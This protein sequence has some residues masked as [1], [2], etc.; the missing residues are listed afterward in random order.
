M[1]IRTSVSGG[2]LT[3]AR[4]GFQAG[5]HGIAF[6]LVLLS[7][8]AHSPA[9]GAVGQ[10]SSCGGSEHYL[11]LGPPPSPTQPFMLVIEAGAPALS[12]NLIEA[13][14]SG[15]V[16]TVTLSGTTTQA[17]QACGSVIVTVPSAGRYEIKLY[18]VRDGLAP[19][20]A[21][22]RIVLLPL[23]SNFTFDSTQAVGEIAF[24]HSVSLDGAAQV[25]IPIWVPPGRQGIQPS[26]QLIYSSRGGDGALGIGW[27][28]GGLS[29]ITACRRTPAVDEAFGGQYP[30]R[31]CLDGMR[32]VEN[33]TE[34]DSYRNII[35]HGS[36]A[37]PDSFD[38]FSA[39]GMIAR[40]GSRP[41]AHSVIAGLVSRCSWG[42]VNNSY[43]GWDDSHAG[44]SSGGSGDMQRR[45][46]ML[47]KVEDRFGNSME[48]DY[49]TAE[50]LLP[51]EIR[52]TYH[53]AAPATKKI[54]LEYEARP[55]IRYTSIAGLTYSQSKRLK[56]IKIMGPLGL[57]HSTPTN[58]GLLRRYEISYFVHPVTLQSTVQQVKECVD[59]GAT[60]ICKQ[61]LTF[62]YSGSDGRMTYHD[63]SFAIDPANAPWLLGLFDGFRTADI[64]GD[65][66]DDLLY[67]NI[68]KG[69]TYH[70]SNGATFGSETATGILGKFADAELGISLV[71][72]NRDQTVDG[73]IP[74]ASSGDYRIARG[75]VNGSFS[76]SVLPNSLFV[77]ADPSLLR[78]TA[79]GDLDGDTLPDLA[80]RHKCRTNSDI[81][82]NIWCRWATAKNI[83]SELTIEFTNA[84][85]FHSSGAPCVYI[86][87]NA[88][89][90]NCAETR[91]GDPAFMIDLDGNGQ[92]EL[93][94]PVRKEANGPFRERDYSLELRALSFPIGTGMT[95][96]GTGLSS[97][98]MPRVF[99]DVNGDGL[100]DAA[101]V[102]N[103]SLWVAMNVGGSF[104]SPQRAPISATAAAAISLPNEMRVG[105]FNNDGLEDVYLV[106]ADIL[107]QANG[108][109]GFV[110]RSL[111]LPAGT[112]SCQTPI[113]PGVTRRRWDQTLDFNGDGL[114]DF[115]QM[116]AGQIHV[117][118][119]G[120][121]AP[122][123]LQT[124]TGGP[125][126]PEVRFTYDS[127]P[128]VHTPGTCTYPQYCLRKGMRLVAE[129]GVKA[130]VA[131]QS[132]PAGFNRTT[133]RY[134]GGRF[135]Q[136]GRGWLGFAEH[137]KTDMQTGATVTT[138][139]DNTTRQE[140]L[141]NPSI[142][143][144]PG[145]LR[146]VQEI[147]RIDS[148]IAGGDTGKIHRWTLNY[149]YDDRF[150][151]SLGVRVGVASS[152]LVETRFV[153]E[154]ATVQGSAIGP[155]VPI[156]S[157]RELFIRNDF[158]LLMNQIGE[159][160]EGG[161]TTN[162]LIPLNAKVTRLEITRTPSPVN[163]QD[164]L[165]RR[166]DRLI[167]TSTEPARDAVM[168]SARE[169][170]RPGTPKQV[171]VRT[172]DV[173]WKSGTTAIDRITIEP[174]RKA[175]ASLYSV[176]E[177]LHDP[178]GNIHDIQI[179]A[180]SG[181]GQTTH[182]AQIDWDPLDQTLEYRR[183]NA[184]Q[185][186][187]TFYYHAGIG[188][189]VAH[190]DTNGLRTTRILDL[191]GRSRGAFSPSLAGSEISYSTS[192]GGLLVVTSTA[193][194][195]ELD[196]RYINRYGLTVREETS[197]LHG[198]MSIVTR[199]FTRLNELETQT[200]PHYEDEQTES[201]EFSYDNL[202]RITERS[203]GHA[204]PAPA[205]GAS[206]QARDVSR[207]S[208]FWTYDGLTTQH[209]NARGV[210]SITSFDAAGRLVR[211]ATIEPETIREIV[212]R[213]EYGPFDVVDAV[214][215]SAGN[216]IQNTYDVLGRRIHMMDPAFGDTV[217]EYNGY[218]EA[219]DVH[220][221]AGIST[222]LE[223]D[224]LG[225]IFRE[226]HTTPTGVLVDSFVWDTAANGL[227]MLAEATSS[228]NI[229]TT[230]VYDILGRLSKKQWDVPTGSHAVTSYALETV[231]D[232]YD[233]PQFLKYPPVGSR[234]LSLQYHYEPQG[235]LYKITNPTT[236]ELYWT[237][238]KQDASG[239]ALT[240]QFMNSITTNRYLDSR[241]R[242]KLLETVRTMPS[243]GT[244]NNV[245][246]LQ[247]LAYEYGSGGLIRSRH[248]VSED[249]AARIT[250]DFSYDFLGRLMYW[251]AFQNCRVSQ[252]KYV[253]D[254][255]GNVVSVELKAGLGRNAILR[256]GSSPN[257]PHAGPCAVR[258]LEED[259]A[260]TV[261]QYDTGGRQ[262]GDGGR[263]ITWSEFDLPRRIQTAT[264]DITFKYDAARQRTV[265]QGGS[266]SETVSI[267]AEY[268]KYAASSGDRHVFNLVG[269]AGVFGQVTWTSTGADETAFFYSD[270][271]G[272]PETLSVDAAANASQKVKYEPFGQRRYPL[273]IA[274]PASVPSDRSIG[275]TGHKAE[276][277]FGLVDMRGRIYDPRIM[278][279]LT[280]DPLVQSPLFSQALNRY[281]YVYNNPV[282]FTDPTGFQCAD[283]PTCISQSPGGGGGGGGGVGGPVTL[284]SCASL[285]PLACF[286]GNPNSSNTQPP[287]R[288]D[289]SR[290]GSDAGPGWGDAA[291]GVASSTLNV[292]GG[293]D[294]MGDALSSADLD[295]LPNMPSSAIGL[296]ALVG[297]L[298]ERDYLGATLNF[299]DLTGL[300]LEAGANWKA[301]QYGRAGKIFKGGAWRWAK[302]TSKGGEYAP[303]P[304]KARAGPWLRLAGLG[305]A[306]SALA[307][308]A[309]LATAIGDTINSA[310]K[311][312][313]EQN[314]V[315]LRNRFSIFSGR[316]DLMETDPAYK[317]TIFY[318]TDMFSGTP[319]DPS[320][321]WKYPTH[322][323]PHQG[324]GREIDPSCL[325]D[326]QRWTCG[327]A[328]PSTP[329]IDYGIDWGP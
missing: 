207:D 25:T 214:T 243:T 233:R 150:Q 296:M 219:V 248:D 6:L 205:L 18:V 257:S 116:R 182:T 27:Q 215:D 89:L 290:R 209:T 83:S 187:E 85:D 159:S 102:E 54:V 73:V 103:G 17:P 253:Y 266:A 29:A 294:T 283:G 327:T 228:D 166:Y 193:S 141:S 236:G 70:L 267:G 230:Y 303:V 147:T 260:T 185:Q 92:N 122:G 48:I 224:L 274:F 244:P 62:T 78:I 146:P 138:T 96:R 280:P 140:R 104:A 162:N 56:T 197:R 240:E 117:L 190:D 164:W 32:I 97:K 286:F 186:T 40:Y 148:R 86:H 119:R 306:L 218:G 184:L 285:N 198:N 307:A 49:D 295:F 245:A 26:L 262:I 41:A 203:I 328:S 65:G 282:N 167:V 136:R 74:L 304:S 35:A 196:R 188:R 279:F 300:G 152:V 12:S 84:M 158:G 237:L 98:Q 16:I 151:Q 121:P 254:D 112:D 144:Y 2:R 314:A 34:V 76:S 44:C 111:Q 30:D 67:D 161:F 232:P 231:W 129:V 199:T 108:Q 137:V 55:D 293:L 191:F 281:S 299:L 177:F 235:T 95:Q 145:A 234:Q 226:S 291:A 179:T 227:G 115:V 165:V 1:P 275:F 46:W 77:S 149:R 8:F 217:T 156:Q 246:V 134:A 130:N 287:T 47:D 324:Y 118:E 200:L 64:N 229:K 71:N 37:Y 323:W 251:T 284:Y 202:R 21:T 31:F 113:C 106:S 163:V 68:H 269:P 250:E 128:S 100:V 169:P 206:L 309:G 7:V 4:S 256:Y 271:V 178:T 276:D 315:A 239:L 210:R 81:E 153:S 308:R 11:R 204:S 195:G 132:Y 120:G 50:R 318:F 75:E 170:A 13:L 45:A 238:R 194:S 125:L 60:A 249:R 225:R 93:I 139:M 216:R 22:S 114:I 53:Q 126:T 289:T 135:D 10:V 189:L 264:E 175:D 268:E 87:S 80:I 192:P 15:T 28:L 63:R 155:F 23:L 223:R 58:V 154:E 322:L 312:Y 110:E 326:P 277:E 220:D 176:T 255:L 181:M 211:N 242:L 43:V 131:D 57:S 222:T 298:K 258:E 127:T 36:G 288:E 9:L 69:L 91:P 329:P 168:A 265:K 133:Y 105:D 263:S 208:E 321:S 273:V 143:R 24:Q 61:P 107:L 90:S 72:L 123:L 301:A 320:D 302:G 317:S 292:A 160:F 270:L 180:N 213:T 252:Q 124:I 313:K 38:V 319:P 201:V 101:H 33:S 3:R 325:S 316:K 20:L 39:D 297:S 171:T 42:Y 157:R 14:G 94:V 261:F 19:E 51:V 212:T 173:R 241:K 59:E 172:I 247:R 52:Y 99:L 82:D 174:D 142:Y 310:P 183:T 259:G 79:V 88:P 311:Y 272:T 109:L 278:R 305:N 66:F 221:G 5:G